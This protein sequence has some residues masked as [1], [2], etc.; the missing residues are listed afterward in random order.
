MTS[1][2]PARPLTAARR[3][4][5]A[6]A[7]GVVLIAVA[8]GLAVSDDSARPGQ[9]LPIWPYVVIVAFAALIALV[10]QLYGYRVP[11]LPAGLPAEEAR[12]RGL[13]AFTQS[14]VIRFALC[15]SVA[16]VSI[17]LT[18][19]ASP[20]S[21]QTYYLGGA[22][23]LILMAYHV[24]PGQQVVGRVQQGLDREGG[25]SDLVT[26]LTGSEY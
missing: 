11:T 10:V 7:G 14:M 4:T 3:L 9:T 12:E 8:L 23:A 15:E 6:L 5:L 13:Q 20:R 17:A 18:F 24:W 16:L 21:V 1:K 26:A 19:V 22:A 2:T 25:H